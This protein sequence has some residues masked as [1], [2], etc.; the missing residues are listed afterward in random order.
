MK[1]LKVKFMQFI[2]I[3]FTWCTVYEKRGCDLVYLQRKQEIMTDI[4]VNA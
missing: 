1:K 2:E 3:Q 4:S